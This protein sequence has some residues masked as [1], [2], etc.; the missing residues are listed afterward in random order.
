M[1]DD[2]FLPHLSQFRDRTALV[3]RE[4][5]YTYRELLDR[6]EA[7]R[8]VLRQRG[9]KPGQCVA[10]H[11]GFSPGT[12]TLLLALVAERNIAVPLTTAVAAE[13]DRALEI[14]GASWLVTFAGDDSW[15]IDKVSRG[16]ES[17][18]AGTT[19]DVDGHP[20]IVDFRKT[21]EAGMIM[22]SSGSTGAVKASLHSFAKILARYRGRATSPYRSLAFL[23]LDHV[24]GINT[25]FHILASGGTIVTLA[26]RTPEAICSGIERHRVQL[27]PTTPTFLRMLMISEVYKKYDLSSLEL[28][29]YG[30][31]PMPNATLAAL[32]AALP[33][34]RLKQTYGLTEVG[35][36]PTKSEGDDSLW[37]AVGGKGYETKV[38]DG[39]L[40]IRSQSAMIG[41]LNAP[42]PFDAD[43]WMNTGDLVEQKGD[44]IRFLGRKSEIINIG[45]EK[46]F[47]AEVENV[48]QQLDNIKEVTVRGR[49]SPITGNIVIATVELRAPEDPDAL[50]E[51]VRAACRERLAPFKVPAMVEIASE[52]LCGNRFKKKRRAN[53]KSGITK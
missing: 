42:S 39:V 31:E 28:I 17:A 11:G 40:W 41:Y 52:T 1:G 24:G 21:G 7:W 19:N 15:T 16:E 37:L 36:L 30:T 8:E 53:Q 5:S 2:W 50:E 9:T 20:L 34:V 46:V 23:M 44:Y 49:S 27:L 10:L 47:P 4:N 14:A 38:V 3:W 51:R 13:R 25:L 32:H 18:Q 43:G 22:L 45:G 6:V 33:G 35:V 48:I 29:S 26:E 12:A